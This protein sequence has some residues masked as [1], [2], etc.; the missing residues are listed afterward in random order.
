MRIT[1]F[2]FLF[3]VLQQPNAWAQDLPMADT[4][5]E[6]GKIWVVVISVLVVL[7]G[8]LAYLVRLDG[9]ISKLEKKKQA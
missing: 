4:L 3:L 8:F 1:I 5:R 7:I 9:R 6:D 2:L